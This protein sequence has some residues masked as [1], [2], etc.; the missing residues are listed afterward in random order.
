[1]DFREFKTEGAT[2]EHLPGVGRPG[3]ES[4]EEWQLSIPAGDGR[5]YRVA[6]IDD[7]MSKSRGDF[8]WQAPLEMRLEACASAPDLPGTWG[9]GLWNDPF[10]MGVL[11]GGRL[12]LPALP[13]TAWFFFASPQNYLSLRDDQPGHGQLAAVFRSPPWP[14][15]WLVAGAPAVPLLAWRPTARLLRRLARPFVRQTA[16][17]LA[18][19]PS[20]WHSYRLRCDSQGTHFWVDEAPVFETRLTPRG[21]LGLVLWI[22]NQYMALRPDGQ[23]AYGWLANPEPAW[24]KIRA[25]FLDSIA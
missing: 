6:Q 18:I 1:M 7:Y 23:A 4:P 22:D 25:I 24:I 20:Q 2:I 16:T 8:P 3:E 17:G 11:A 15:A 9:F 5:A 10:S 21:K 12:R 19:D 13:N 14:S